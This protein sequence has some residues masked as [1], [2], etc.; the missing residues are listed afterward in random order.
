MQAGGIDRIER[1]TSAFWACLGPVLMGLLFLAGVATGLFVLTE[2]VWWQ[3]LVPAL[4]GAILFGVLL[5]NTTAR[6]A[7]RPVKDLSELDV[8]LPWAE[9]QGSDC[10]VPP[11]MAPPGAPKVASSGAPDVAI[12]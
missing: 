10:T 2:D 8:Q 7:P 1:G 5:W 6:L 12:R 9:R 3:R 11:E 4:P